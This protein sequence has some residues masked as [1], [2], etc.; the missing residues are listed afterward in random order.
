M[1]KKWHLLFLGRRG[2]HTN[3][4]IV[5]KHIETVIISIVMI[6]KL[7]HPLNSCTIRLKASSMV[8]VNAE[9]D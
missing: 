6:G 9:T 4:Y 3:K 1:I 8:R 7:Q 2:L 5:D